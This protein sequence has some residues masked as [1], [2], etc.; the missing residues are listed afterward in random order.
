MRKR[1]CGQ[2][3]VKAPLSNCRTTKYCDPAVKCQSGNESSN[4]MIC[5]SDGRFYSSE[6]H[7]LKANCGR[8]VHI[9]PMST[10]LQSFAFVFRGCSRVCPST[11][12]PVCGS[13]NKTYSNQCFMDMEQCRGKRAL[14]TSSNANA[15]AVY[16][17]H[18]GKCGEPRTKARN[19]LY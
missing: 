3:V 18:D 12:D 1:T 5:A 4:Q 7:M 14:Q 10:C 2:F 16:K 13:D 9:V 19:Y 15:L 6:C 8:H 17:K 11:F